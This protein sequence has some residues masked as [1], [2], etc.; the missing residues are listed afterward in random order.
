MATYSIGWKGPEVERIQVRLK[1]LGFYHG[2][3]DSDFGGGTDAAVRAYQR[4]KGLVADG[5]VGPITWASLFGTDPIPEPSI[6]SKSLGHKCLALTGSFE[7]DKM[8]PDCFAGLSG[9]FDEQGVSFGVLQ[10]NFGQQSLQPLLQ[11]MNTAHSSI[12]QDIFAQ[13]YQTLVEILNKD[14]HQQMEWAR[15]IQHPVQHVI[16]EPWRGYFKTLG[17]TKEFQEIQVKYAEHLHRKAMDLCQEYQLWSQ[18]AVALMFDILT[19]NGSISSAVKQTI[20]KE[21]SELNSG[22]DKAT[23]EVE[24]MRIIANQRAE[25]SKP[26]WVED[27]RSRKLACANGEAIVHGITYHLSEQFGINLLPL[28]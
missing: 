4:S 15:S 3:I 5:K 16:Y 7:T 22:L 27:V 28:S 8:P 13:E 9:D 23:F 14:F 6:L 10:W 19:Q 11:E 26:Q 21:I 12:L 18:R 20:M 24:K 17:R 1:E 25:A 2:P